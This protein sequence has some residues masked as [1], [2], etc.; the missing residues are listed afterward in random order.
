MKTLVMV[1]W[2]EGKGVGVLNTVIEGYIIYNGVLK[3]KT[4][5]LERCLM[6]ADPYTT[7]KCINVEAYTLHSIVCM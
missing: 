6:Q 2:W 7:E 4:S 5:K 1:L 3:I